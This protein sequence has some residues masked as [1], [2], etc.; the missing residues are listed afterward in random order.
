MP[1]YHYKA[2]DPYGKS[3]T[4]TI[5]KPDEAEVAR[6]FKQMGYVT[7]QIEAAELKEAKQE[8]FLFKSVK[9]VD[10]N[11]FTR[12]LA[13]LQKAGLPITNSLAAL[14]VQTENKY[15]KHVVS[16]IKVRVEGGASLSEAFSQYPTVFGGLY[17]AMVRT[18]ETG[19]ILDQALERLA[20]LGEYDQKT[21]DKIKQAVRY[22]MMVVATLA[23]S[24]TVLLTFVVPRFQQLFDQFGAALPLPT[25]IL[26]GASH[27]VTAY[28][29]VFILG[30]GAFI[31][32]FRMFV[33]SPFGR[34]AWDGVLLKLPVFGRLMTMLMM[35]RFARTS[36][37]LMR[38]G[39]PILETL[40]LA[41]KTVQNRVIADSIETI[42]TGVNEGKGISEPMRVSKVFP[43]MVYHMVALG[44]ES[45]ELDALLARVADYY[46]QQSDYIIQNM[47]T[48]IEPFLLFGLGGIV[49]FVALSIFLPMWRVSGLF[50]NR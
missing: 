50:I 33:R 31:A 26:I 23:I 44:E 21:R 19:G 10:L 30:L 17:V 2:R 42:R 12:Q 14:E 13:T 39:L 28:W 43:P 25:K 47:T 34:R 38:T 1:T 4:G 48:L 5:E 7:T 16:G 36:A 27:A 46:D 20:E 40:E 15:F 8:R 35:S 22:P 9:S 24:I 45:G 37:M 32:A 18:G 49:L 29:W 3:V 11:L 6:H 41:S